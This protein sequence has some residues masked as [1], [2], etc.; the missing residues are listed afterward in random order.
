M[1]RYFRIEEFGL[2]ADQICRW[3]DGGIPFGIVRLPGRDGFNNDLLAVWG[4]GQGTIPH[5]LCVRVKP[6]L[7]SQWLN[8]TAAEAADIPP[9][10]VCPESTPMP[11]YLDMVGWLVRRL[12][13]RGGK[14]V[15]CRNI[16]G[17]FGANPGAF[18]ICGLIKR[19]FESVASA[20]TL[21]FVFRHPRT[22][23]W[24]GSTPE[25]I[26][27]H[28]LG[29]Y[30]TMALAGTMPAQ[31]TEPW[32][33]KNIDEHEIVADYMQRRLGRSGITFQRSQRGELAADAVKHLCTRFRSS[34]QGPVRRDAFDALVESVQPTPALAGYPRREAIDEIH[35]LELWHRYFYAG[36][37]N[38][39]DIRN[40]LTFGLIRCVHFDFKRWSIYTGS[41]ITP[42]SD[43]MQEWE[44]TAAKARPL[45][46]LFSSFSASL[47]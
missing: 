29:G 33:Q 10:P 42:D 2:L 27:E 37:I 28:N 5:A 23:F 38:L 6:W 47:P 16:S 25:L 40:N 31:A 44:E 20:T 36:L 18:G 30:S 32:S 34:L 17:S 19:Y 15:I 24:M 1:H 4:E 46:D 12:R 7:S 9:M 26:M 22:G 14:T 11:V 3:I 13:Q 39:A 8:L 45:T 43:P 35:M 41:G 21:T